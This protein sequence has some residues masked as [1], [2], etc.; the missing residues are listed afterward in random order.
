MWKVNW[1]ESASMHNFIVDFDLHCTNNI[2]IGMI[3][4]CIF[5]GFML[6]AFVFPH[7]ADKVGR[8]KV[9]F[10]FFIIHIG[11][12]ALVS[13]APNFYYL[14]AGF[15]LIGLGSTVRTA[16]GFVHAC[17]LVLSHQ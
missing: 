2:Y 8:K 3:G 4:S 17:E 10:R 13:L 14:Y 9:F 6:G 1:N 7:L 12:T 15:F 16:V 5:F 11:G